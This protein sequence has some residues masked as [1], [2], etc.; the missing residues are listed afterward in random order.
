MRVVRLF[1]YVGCACSLERIQSGAALYAFMLSK[2][3]PI[4]CM[5]EKKNPM[6]RLR[7]AHFQLCM[8]PCGVF[9]VAAF[10]IYAG[11]S[12][13]K[14]GLC[15]LWLS[16][17]WQSVA[18]SQSWF[19]PLKGARVLHS[20]QHG[21]PC[22]NPSIYIKKPHA[23]MDFSWRALSKPWVFINPPQ[24]VSSSPWE[25]PQYSYFLFLLFF[26]NCVYPLNSHKTSTPTFQS[27][28]GIHPI[29]NDHASKEI[30]PSKYQSPCDRAYLPYF[31]Y[32]TSKLID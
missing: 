7:C 10:F 16:P 8:L 19:S 9:K 6:V 11:C 4:P 22:A 2:W 15:A 29:S 1:F 17:K 12:S 31:P 14:I 18:F 13:F 20:Y 26:K 21:S 5:M 23:A 32:K 27:Q 24:T 3:P 28:Y 30:P 25:S